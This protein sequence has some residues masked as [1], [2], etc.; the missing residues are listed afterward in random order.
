MFVKQGNKKN[1]LITAW[2]VRDFSEMND[3]GNV[4][5]KIFCCLENYHIYNMEIGFATYHAAVK[6]QGICWP[7][8]TP[9]YFMKFDFGTEVSFTFNESVDRFLSYCHELCM[10]NSV[11]ESYIFRQFSLNQ[12]LMLVS[13]CFTLHFQPLSISDVLV[14]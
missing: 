13:V 4:L 8:S 3:S 10:I 7:K 12:L 11:L 5:F 1:G 14:V 9:E 2:F 6:K